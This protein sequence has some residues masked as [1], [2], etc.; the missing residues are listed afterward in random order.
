[1]IAAVGQERPVK[2]PTP[3]RGVY[4]RRSFTSDRALQLWLRRGFV[5][6]QLIVNTGDAFHRAND[7]LDALLQ[8]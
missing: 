3:W 7:L 1:M 8:F 6:Y 2:D 5:D 4:L